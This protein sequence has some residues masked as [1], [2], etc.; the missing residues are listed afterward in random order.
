M[1]EGIHLGWPPGEFCGWARLIL[2]VGQYGSVEGEPK[3]QECSRTQGR[4][5]AVRGCAVALLRGSGS[6]A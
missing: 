1:Y 4:T 2:S 3:S 5:D 6:L